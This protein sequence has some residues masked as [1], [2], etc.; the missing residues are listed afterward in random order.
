MPYETSVPFRAGS[1]G[2]SSFRIPACVLAPDGALLAFAEGRVNSSGDAGD[3]D[4]VSRRSADGGLSW[5][6]MKVVATFGSGTAGN[7]SPV[8]IPAPAGDPRTTGCIALVFVTNGAEATESRIRRGEV[9]A[10]DARRVWVQ[11]SEDAGASWSAPVEI[12]ETAKLP[13]WRWYATTPGHA[14]LLEQG[15]YA[16]RIVVPANH[17]IPPTGEDVGTEGRYNGGHDLL[18]DDGGVTWSIGYVDDNPDGQVNVNETTAAELPDGRVYFN[19][20]TEAVAPEHRADAHS[21]DGGETLLAPFRPQ[22]ALTAPV[23]E[24]SVLQLRDPDVLLFSAPAD[25]EERRRM[26][27]RASLDGGANWLPVHTVDDLP[28]AYSD[29]VRVDDGTLGLLYETGETSPY[30]T[31]TFRR[32]AVRELLE[33]AAR[34]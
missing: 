6:E 9:G 1:E 15:P 28:A 10:A 2:Y 29:L 11:R 5:E 17:S 19:T 21:A 31:I 34:T 8:V 12:T 4:I 32:I 20:R 22:P 23:V 26:T 30:S 16:G 25:P 3:I 33:A 14:L 13:H 7:P 18:S 27:V 24:A